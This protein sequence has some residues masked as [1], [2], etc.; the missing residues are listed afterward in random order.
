MLRRA[1]S[2]RNISASSSYTTSVV[3]SSKAR[4]TRDSTETATIAAMKQA[5]I[6]TPS[7]RT[8]TL[9]IVV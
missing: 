5:P 4:V 2:R 7:G 1:Q 9:S 8:R 6:R 3:R